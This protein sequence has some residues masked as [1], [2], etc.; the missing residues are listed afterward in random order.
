MR[1][2]DPDSSFQDAFFVCEAL[3]TV[4]FFVSTDTTFT[5]TAKKQVIIGNMENTVIDA[6]T[7]KLKGFNNILIISLLSLLI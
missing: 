6:S 5:Y 4:K 7:S 1:N 2:V 3:K